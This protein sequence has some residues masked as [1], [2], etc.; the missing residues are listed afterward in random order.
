MLCC[1]LQC[2]HSISSDRKLLTTLIAAE[3]QLTYQHNS[4]ENTD[5]ILYQSFYRRQTFTFLK[6][7]PGVKS[8]EAVVSSP[9]C[10]Y[11]C[12]IF[13][14][15]KPKLDKTIVSCMYNLL[16]VFCLLF[17]GELLTSRDSEVRLWLRVCV[18][19]HECKN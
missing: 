6:T 19:P 11:K 14:S 1:R 15:P 12:V 18:D 7:T 16:T 13:I 3:L 17:P 8:G 5:S 2:L 4:P 9:R 10:R